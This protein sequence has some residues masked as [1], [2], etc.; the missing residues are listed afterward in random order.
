MILRLPDVIGPRDN[1]GRFWT[2]LLWLRF[3][4]VI[5]R[6][7]VLPSKLQNK[8]LSFVFSEDVANLLIHLPDYED[9]VFNFAYNVAFLD[10]VTLEDFLRMAAGHLGISDV[11]F[12]KST[13]DGLHYFPSVTR[14]AID[15]SMALH[16]LHWNPHQ[17]NDGIR[18]T[19]QFYEYA[20][21]SSDF[22]AQRN[23]ILNSFSVP[24]HAME[25]FKKRLKDVYGV[26]Y[27]RDIV[28][29]EL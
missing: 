21:R 7:L 6:P 20:M 12:D 18:K 13:E 22:K 26:D 27:D 28:K 14:G 11:N 29:D 5:D 2:Y 25:A 3:H 23:A 15:V 4:D 24:P 8:P 17:L 10:T 9:G 16:H 19:V 1:T